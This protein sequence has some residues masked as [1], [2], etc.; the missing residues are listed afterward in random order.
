MKNVLILF[1]GNS[2]EHKISCM[3]VNFIINNIDTNK[4]NY[5]LVGIDYDNTWYEVKNTD[6]IDEYWKN[7]SIEKIDNIIE[8][9]KKFD[10]VF[11]IIHG[12]TCEDGKL[13]SMFEMYNIRYVGCDS[14]SS[15]VCYDK[16][17]TKLILENML[18]IIIILV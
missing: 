16:L 8:Y 14:Y 18:F 11:P 2:F 9:A 10:I 7:K 5:K 12:N 3:S 4:F 17:L 13:Q 6:N 1:G 15:I